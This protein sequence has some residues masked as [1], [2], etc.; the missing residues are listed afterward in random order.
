MSDWFCF[1][2]GCASS[3]LLGYVIG[4]ARATIAKWRERTDIA[5]LLYACLKSGAL[6]RI[7]QVAD[8]LKEG[9]LP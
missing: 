3:L 9:G 1:C 8:I 5:T 7:R 6:D 2:L 4:T